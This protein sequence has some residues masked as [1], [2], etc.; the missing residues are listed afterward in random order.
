MKFEEEFCFIIKDNPQDVMNRISD[1]THIN[2]FYFIKQEPI[3]LNDIYMDTD[4]GYLRSNNMAL[5]VRFENDVKLVTYKRTIRDN[6]REE[7]E[8]PYTPE[9]FK[10]IRKKLGVLDKGLGCFHERT[11]LRRSFKVKNNGVYVADVCLDIVQPANSLIWF[12]EVE[13]EKK[14][15]NHE[16]FLE[17][18]KLLKEKFD[19]VEWPH[20]KVATCKKIEELVDDKKFKK[21]VSKSGLV[22]LYK[23]SEIIK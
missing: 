2:N 5:R 8:F 17:L 11:T 22:N 4:D 13:V 23:A 3:K 15:K 21:L 16:A 19:L 10:M 18:T 6:K 14:S 1:V 12:Y 20:S 9:R 7:K